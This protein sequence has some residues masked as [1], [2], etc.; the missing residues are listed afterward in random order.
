MPP[1]KKTREKERVIN[2]DEMLAV[3]FVKHCAR[4]HRF[5]MRFRTRNEH[6][7]DHRLHADQLDH[8]H[9][10]PKGEHNAEIQDP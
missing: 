9:A 6:N 4:R 10:E 1:R 3:A 5:T 7:Q 2:S 8:I